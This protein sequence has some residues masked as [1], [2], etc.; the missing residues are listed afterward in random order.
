MKQVLFDYGGNAGR[1]HIHGYEET[2]STTTAFDMMVRNRVD[3][4]H[5]ALSAF[6]RAR[7]IG[8][9]TPA[10]HDRLEALY[11]EKLA[12]HRAYIMEHGDDP[13]DITNWSWHARS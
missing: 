9:L 4:F 2:G 11:R 3:R 1:F 6:A 12:V 5:L 13:A 10:E 7:E 8:V